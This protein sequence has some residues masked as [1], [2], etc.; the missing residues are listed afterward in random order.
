MTSGLDRAMGALLGLAC[1]D[2]VG[3]TVE[4]S[5][6]GSFVPLTDMTGGGPSICATESGRTTRRCD[7][8][9]VHREEI[10]G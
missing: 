6:P 8:E 3:T 5:A 1:V 9:K 4:F 7:G 2:G 10:V